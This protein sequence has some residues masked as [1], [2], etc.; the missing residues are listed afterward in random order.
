MDAGPRRRIGRYEIHRELG[1]GGMGVVYAAR[2]PSLQREVA[3]KLQLD[4]TSGPSLRRFEREARVLARLDDPHLVRV[5][6]HG[7][8][9]ERPYLVM[10]LI[11]GASLQARL[12]EQGPLPVQEAVRITRDLARTLDRVHREGVL[13]RDLKPDNVLQR[14]DGKVVLTDFGLARD[15]AAEKARLTQ[16]GQVLGTPAFMAPEQA[17]GEVQAIDERTDV[18]GLGAT[19]F[20]LLTGVPPFQGSST[21]NVISAVLSKPAPAPSKQRPE[22]PRRLDAICL[23]C[24][25]KEPAD[26]YATAHDLAEALEGV[27]GRDGPGSRSRR[28]PLLASAAILG[29]GAL[30]VGRLLSQAQPPFL[31]SPPAL[32][33]TPTST[34][35]SPQP[36]ARWLERPQGELHPGPREGHERACSYDTSR[37][38]FLLLSGHD[39]ANPR[40][41]GVRAQLWGWDGVRWTRLA[42]NGSANP[43]WR[44]GHAAAY[45]ERRQVLVMH[46]GGKAGK[47]IEDGVWEWRSGDDR[48]EHIDVPP[49]PGVASLSWHSMVYDPHRE[50]MLV[51]GGHSAPNGLTA[52]LWAWKNRRWTL[53]D[54]GQAGPPARQSAGLAYDVER[55]ELVLFGGWGGRDP[56][57]VHDDTLWRWSEELRWR[58]VEPKGPQPPPAQ[59][60]SF[61]ATD[62]GF[63]LFGGFSYAP[64]GGLQHDA[65]RLKGDRWEA[66]DAPPPPRLWH[67]A[68]WDRARQV[69]V[70]YGGNRHE[71]TLGDLW[72][73]GR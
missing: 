37:R 45:D 12:R 17:S 36:S 4:L 48:W 14:H 41:N 11:L 18:Y 66:L 21:I 63:V 19:L 57:A 9:G 64:G 2:D 53:L 69:L 50:R 32:E 55:R 22:L 44:Y 47:N 24:L 20:A 59:A 40:P 6:D 29:L 46:G 35:P 49:P 26:R 5:L 62:D 33:E 70:I 31:P 25:E 23:R 42:Q 8:D 60:S 13:H 1:R 15:A 52:R 54:D 71:I 61:T 7:H 10:D 38:L 68:A 27:L 28:G 67:G 56:S 65:W 51:F 43:T 30:V 58:P 72:E 73:Y 39:R 16:T 3:V 34:P